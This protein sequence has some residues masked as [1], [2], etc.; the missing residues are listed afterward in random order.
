MEDDPSDFCADSLLSTMNMYSS[1]D[2]QISYKKRVSSF[3]PNVYQKKTKTHKRSMLTII[4]SMIYK[5][6][7]VWELIRLR[8]RNKMSSKPHCKAEV[9][10]IEES[11]LLTFL[12]KISME[13]FNQNCLGRGIGAVSHL[14]DVSASDAD[15]FN[16]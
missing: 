3:S 16:F 1:I 8:S 5:A 10:I 15:E 13:K 9:R 4:T 14:K 11:P 6:C 2:K 12:N 7:K